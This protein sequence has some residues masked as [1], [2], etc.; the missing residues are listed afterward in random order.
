MIYAYKRGFAWLGSRLYYSAGGNIEDWTGADTGSIDISPDDGDEIVGAVLFKKTIFIFKGP[1]N[2]S[3]HTISGT[4]PTGSDAFV[5]APF[6]AGI[7]LQSHNSIVPIGS[8]RVGDAAADISFMSPRGI[9]LLSA[10]QQYGDFQESD[11]TRYLKR[12]FRENVNR[13][14]FNR[15]WG[16]NYREKSCL[17]WTTT[18]A[19]SASNDQLF[20]ISYA[21]LQEDG[22]KPF[23][24]SRP[25]QS[26]AIRKNPVSRIDEIITGNA[27]GFV[28]RQDILDRNIDGVAYNMDVVTPRLILAAA[29]KTGK[30]RGDQ[31]VVLDRCFIRADSTGSYNLGVTIERDN[32]PS[33]NYVFGLGIDMSGF[34]LDQSLLDDGLIGGDA[35]ELS[36]SDPPL[37][38]ECRT[39]RF[40]LSQNG[41]DEDA[42]LIELGIECNPAA[43]SNR[44]PATG[45]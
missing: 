34:I 42:S 1:N 22:W 16:V 35:I 20:G 29:D 32:E 33:D 44:S 3:I 45:I 31:P 24:V 4:S 10:V 37:V 14:Y 30:S 2:G 25:C 9:H 27:D 6:S 19:S 12:H 23:T 41:V 13:N 43:Q 18:L 36:W 28:R 26:L 5:L 17:L 40:R 8:Q 21:R 38:G 11:I 39:V 7:P 15:V